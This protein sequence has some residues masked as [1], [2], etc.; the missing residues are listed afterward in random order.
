LRQK[1]WQ[2]LPMMHENAQAS[3]TIS[4]SLAE[5][6]FNGLD[7]NG[8]MLKYRNALRLVP[9]LSKNG[10]C[11]T[12]NSICAIPPSPLVLLNICRCKKSC[13]T[14]PIMLPLIQGGS[15]ILAGFEQ[16]L[17]PTRTLNEFA[18]EF[19]VKYKLRLF[20]SVMNLLSC[21]AN[22]GRWN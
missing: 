17:R 20:R 8:K 9:L 15:L 16:I 10:M 3:K 18:K 14:M 5:A 11:Q 4:D 2:E 19:I 7:G 22:D 6:S 13:K 1:P 21:M 12:L